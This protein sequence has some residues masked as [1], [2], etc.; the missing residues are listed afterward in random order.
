[1]TI[2]VL[3]GEQLALEFTIP[4]L[5]RTA[6]ILEEVVIVLTP[7]LITTLIQTKGH[8]QRLEVI[9]I[10][11]HLLQLEVVLIQEEAQARR[12]VPALALLAERLAVEEEIINKTFLFYEKA[13]FYGNGPSGYYLFSSSRYHRCCEIFIR[14]AVGYG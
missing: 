8:L 7:D 11:V 1:M 12:V 5:I 6:L 9:R 4:D 13:I 14:S 3:Q 10:E 2:T